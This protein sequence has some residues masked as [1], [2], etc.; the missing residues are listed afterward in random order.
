MQTLEAKL[1][2]ALLD[3]YER[4]RGYAE[5]RAQKQRIRL[6]MYGDTR[7]DFTDYNIEDHVAR[8]AV[9]DAAQ[10]LASQNLVSLE[11][12][13]GE[14]GHILH[15]ILLCPDAVNDAYRFCA[16][17]P[18]ADTAAQLESRLVQAQQEIAAEWAQQ[19]LAEELDFL[20]RNRRP[21]ANFPTD[22]AEQ[23]GW[24]I[25]LRAA[26]AQSA[27][28]PLLERVCS[29]RY[30]GDS[31]AFENRYRTRLLG[32]LEKHLLPDADEMTAEDRLRQVGLENYPE[33]FSLCGAVR[34]YWSNDRTLDAAP[35]R[36]G[37]QI[38]ALDVQDTTLRLAPQ[39]R[40]LLF[41]ENKA[42]YYDYIRNHTDPTQ[43]VVYHGG[44]Y[45][46]QRGR[47]FQK[48]CRAAGPDVRLLHWGD[49]DLGGFQMDSRLRREIDPRILP[50]RMSMVELA[51]H[52]DQAANFDD[53]YAARLA[54][55]L[56]DPTLHDSRETLLYMLQHRL[57]LEQEVLIE[58]A[59]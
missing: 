30:L 52:R 26:A 7:C 20:R 59:R 17:T 21:R 45:S 43:V 49:I 12:M 38:S 15:R 37:L 23:D 40:T 51:T 55:L 19:Y 16:R 36:D 5:N 28:H 24:L 42:N 39:V 25:V 33:W 41:I 2:N 14:E 31:K 13:R 1:L 54:A 47:F 46:P 44:F 22:G 57:R 18:L 35:L 8:C 53:T 3:G 27:E 6:R 10:V 11:W 34:F 32:V 56:D 58:D 48:L 50:W 29:V 4:S 9:N